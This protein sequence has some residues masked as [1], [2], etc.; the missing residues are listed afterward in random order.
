M[1]GHEKMCSEK[2][3]ASKK[4][5]VL[6][7]EVYNSLLGPMKKRNIEKVSLFIFDVLDFIMKNKPYVCNELFREVM[8]S[9]RKYLIEK[10]ISFSDFYKESKKL[11]EYMREGKGKKWF[12]WDEPEISCIRALLGVFVKMETENDHE[13]ILSDTFLQV[14]ECVNMNIELI[15]EDELIKYINKYFN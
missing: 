4:L 6:V 12:T 1:K 5:D 14:V 7:S 3:V 13:Y 8:D 10:E 15:N 2:R 11:R 9:S